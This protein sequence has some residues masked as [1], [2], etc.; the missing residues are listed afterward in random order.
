MS[1]GFDLPSSSVAVR[2]RAGFPGRDGRRRQNSGP[3][4]RCI[5]VRDRSGDGFI[6][7]ESPT[8]Q[9]HAQNSLKKVWRV[10]EEL[11]IM[12]AIDSGRLNELDIYI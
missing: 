4:A 10:F 7:A 6:A 2:A 9:G 3:R 1:A 5:C 11:K 12:T 8:R